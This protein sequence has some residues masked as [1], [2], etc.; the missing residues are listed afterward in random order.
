MNIRFLL[1]VLLLSTSA[2]AEITGTITGMVIDSSG[3][4]LAGAAVTVRN[5]GTN[6]T[7]NLSTGEDGSFQ[8]VYLPVGEYEITA[9]AEGFNQ[10]M[11]RVVLQVNQVV[12]VVFQLSVADLGEVIE[13]AGQES[14]VTV[15]NSTISTVI[16]NRKVVDL[17]LNG[18]NF[19]QLGTLVPG[20]AG[21]PG[22]GSAE[23]ATEAGP[24]SVCG[25]RDRAINYYIDGADNNQVINNNAAATASVDAIQEFTILTSSYS[26]EYG[27]NSGAVINVVT[28]SGTNDLRGTLFHF[29]R[30][31]ALDANGF[32][33][34]AAGQG[35]A[36]FRNNQF[37]VTLGGAIKRDSTFFF[38]NYEGQRT[39]VGNTIFT[40]V[41]TLLERQ[42]I[43]TDPQTGRQVRVKIDPVAANL[44]KLFPLPNV[45]SQFGNYVSSDVIKLRRDNGLLKIDHKLTSNDQLSFR[46]IIND[47]FTLLPVLSSS[48]VAQDSTQV[49]GYGLKIDAR[50]QNFTASHLR[51]FSGNVINEFRFGYNRF[52]DVQ[53][54]IDTT[55]PATLGLPN[56]NQSALGKGIPQILISGISGIGNSNQ[57]PFTDNLDTFQFSDNL[58]FA[59]GRHN[60]KTGFDIRYLQIDGLQDYSFAG[61]IIFDGS[62]SG[63]SAVADFLQGTPQSAFITRG[64]TAPP[65]RLSNYYFYFL[66]DLRVN[67]RLTINAG[68]RYELNTV[69]TASGKLFNFT[70]DR[71]FFN[72]P[73]YEGDKNNFA[74]RFGFAYTPF[75]HTKTVV[76]G[77]F[78]VF[79][80]L[81]FQ[82]VTFNLTFNPPTARVLYNFGPFVAGKL[83]DIFK[84]GKLDPNGPSLVTIDPRL[85]MPYSYQYNLNIQQELP[86]KIA[87]E[88]AYVGTRALKLIGNI[89][90]NQPIYFAGASLEDIFERRPTQLAGR[91]YGVGGVDSVQ[92]QTGVGSSIYHG[93]Q[94]RLQ[95]SVGDDFALLASYT[96]SKSIDN[97]SDIFGFKGSAGLPQ[98]SR[99]L[100]AE[101]GRSPFDI[102]HRFTFSYTWNLPFGDGKR[103]L[104]SLGKL[105]KLLSG[106]QM[107]GIGTLQTGNPFTV[108]LGIDRALTGN[109]F[110]EQRPNFVPGVF[111]QRSNGQVVLAPQYLNSDGTPNFAALSAA[112]VI[113]AEGQFGTLGR[114]TFV[115]P[116]FKNFDLSLLKRTWLSEDVQL[117]FRAEFFNVFNHP[118]FALPDNTLSS[119]TFGQFSRTPDVASGIPR[120][121]SGSPRVIQFGLKLLF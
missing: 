14:L 62:Q 100:R 77:G 38:L 21:A 82:N 27:R 107:N 70:P 40:N 103:Y 68:V 61:T 51:F 4:A 28:K 95:R 109:L 23:G 102:T 65:I 48:G 84:P 9:K 26:A 114:N 53:L 101:R 2:F 74:P 113:P 45:E 115:G 11:E 106:W 80:D 44:L 89:E 37:G 112:G 108:F 57:F 98:D 120:L 18:R 86:G 41:P 33:D 54:G 36:K 3:A 7:R 59:K 58:S 71:G 22:G 93:L 1:L 78:G 99:N 104:N 13:I 10:G 49:P 32:F 52:V 87:L 15:D 111:I 67:S 94:T 31:D 5:I 119:P 72:E 117:E 16:D 29:L 17:P 66:D 35:K 90:V 34:N 25:Q 50:L 12:R 30:H 118:A 79:Y 55:D 39:R 24:F 75:G 96:Y 105:G 92:Q 110:N 19:L 56:F 43:V 83:G 97:I 63:I 116:G 8:V 76:R 42:G 69:P 73:L 46:Y 91:D 47:R 85:R 81:P 6:L 60:F 20:V 88:V 121:T 64:F